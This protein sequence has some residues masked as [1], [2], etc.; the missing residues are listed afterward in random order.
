VWL[1]RLLALSSQPFETDAGFYLAVV[2]SDGCRYGLAVENLLAPEEIVVKP[3]SKVLRKLRLFS[4]ATVLGDGSL[5][6]ILDIAALATRAKVRPEG[7]R[8][9]LCSPGAAQNRAEKPLYL[10]FEDRFGD[11]T[12]FLWSRWNG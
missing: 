4:G 3:L 2:E 11:R 7:T 12:L 9:A 5:A 8:P 1:D 6:L 10:V